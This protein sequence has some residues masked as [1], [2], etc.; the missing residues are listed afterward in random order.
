MNLVDLVPLDGNKDSRPSNPHGFESVCPI[1]QLKGIE[2]I[3]VVNIIGLHHS[4]MTVTLFFSPCR[5][6]PAV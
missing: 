5:V 1:D 4:N 6:C 3:F 2:P